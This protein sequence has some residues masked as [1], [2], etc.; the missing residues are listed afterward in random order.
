MNSDQKTSGL[1]L[2]IQEAEFIE[3]NDILQSKF[4]VFQ[5]LDLENKEIYY[6]KVLSKLLDPFGNHGLG[7]TLLK[8]FLKMLIRDTQRYTKFKELGIEYIDIDCSLLDDVTI[9]VEKTILSKKR[10]DILI[11]ISNENNTWIIAIENKIFNEES[12]NQTILY[13]EELSTQYPDEKY[14][15][16]Y[17][18]LTPRGDFPSSNKFLPCSWEEI[19]LIL[20]TILKK[21]SI[22]DD[23]RLFLN[24]FS[25]SI[26]V[27]IM[28]NP[29][30]NELCE[31]LFNKYPEVIDFLTK[32]YGK[33]KH[34]PVSDLIRSIV[35]KLREKYQTEWVFFTGSNWINFFKKNWKEKQDQ[36]NWVKTK[37]Q[38]FSLVTFM[39]QITDRDDLKLYFHSYGYDPDDL[40]RNFK[41][42]FTNRS[43]SLDSPNNES[44][45]TNLDN[46]NMFNRVIVKNIS[47]KKENVIISLFL[48][49]LDKIFK[50]YVPIF[51][52]LIRNL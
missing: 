5:L 13:A 48:T 50:D 52:D 43:E 6:S 33:Y 23:V 47:Q 38:Y 27:F 17:V 34:S 4:N 41:K 32:K 44:R 35:T 20:K 10:I 39:C 14:K 40:R 36:N 11:E 51:D 46:R 7:N 37:T 30:L 29:K 26:E 3:L 49:E 2:L 19:F 28:E 25:N 21:T 9:S 45:N 16:I 22:K 1:N 8:E 15:K 18:Y 31:K 42:E 24:H 12:P